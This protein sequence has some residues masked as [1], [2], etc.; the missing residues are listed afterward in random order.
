MTA[1]PDTSKIGVPVRYQGQTVGYAIIGSSGLTELKIHNVQLAEALKWGLLESLSI[2]IHYD[3]R[4]QR[5]YDSRERA[6]KLQTLQKFEA[7]PHCNRCGDTRGGAYG[8]TA[9]E[10]TWKR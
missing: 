2:D 5:E 4:V 6:K 10:C 9:N 8:H 7:N 1:E 3:A